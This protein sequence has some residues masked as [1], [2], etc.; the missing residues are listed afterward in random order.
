MA[1]C[2]YI[3]KERVF[4]YCKS[5]GLFLN[6]SSHP[7]WVK[8]LAHARLITHIRLHTLTLM[9]RV[10]PARQSALC[11]VMACI[12]VDLSETLPPP[13]LPHPTSPS[14]SFLLCEWAWLAPSTML[15]LCLIFLTSSY[16][17]SG[18]LFFMSYWPLTV[19]G[20]TGEGHKGTRKWAERQWVPGQALNSNSS[21]LL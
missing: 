3:T 13:H 9:D 20:G 12:L 15:I 8:C 16:S 18:I 11:S 14:L 1:L 7:R 2:A 6:P 21:A 10:G 4:G 19:G 5:S 17:P